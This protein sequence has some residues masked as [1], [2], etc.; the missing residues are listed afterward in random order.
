VSAPQGSEAWFAERAGHCTASRASD[1]LARIKVG[2]AA[3][4][5]KYRIQV[6]TERLT[7]IPVQGF[8]N[9]AMAWGTQTEPQAREAYEAETGELVQQVGFIKHPEIVWVGASPDG[10]IGDDGL[11]EIKCP[12]S[13]THLEWMDAERLPPKH[14]AQ[15]QFQLWVTGRQWCDFVSYDPRFPEAL[16]LFTLRVKRDD[17]YIENLAGEVCNFL[18]ECDALYLRLTGKR[19]LMDDLVASIANN[20]VS[21]QP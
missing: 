4:R 14:V 12:E 1:V 17:K 20:A 21:T 11:L 2:E 7:G 3:E 10:C 16:R 13:T 5:R 8:Q 15:V 19:T 9:A 18:A 6:V